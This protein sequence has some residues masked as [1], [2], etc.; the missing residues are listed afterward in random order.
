MR[1]S[2]IVPRCSP[3]NS[4]GRYVIELA[5]RL[6]SH[7]SITVYSGMFGD[8]VSTD[9]ERRYLPVPNRPA[10]VRLAALWMTSFAS[11]SRAHEDIVHVQ[12]ADAPVANVVTAQC[13]TAAMR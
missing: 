11:V 7:H 4:H 1:I 9:I 5:K 10:V 3:D 6:K 2:Y 12:G 8:Q 13:C